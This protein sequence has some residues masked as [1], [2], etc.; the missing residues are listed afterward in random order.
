MTNMKN[1]YNWYNFGGNF[2]SQELVIFKGTKEGIYIYI[3][4]GNFRLI[5][6]RVGHE[7]KEIWFFL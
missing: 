2:M 5:K 6:K 7:V 3:K 1:N 4:E